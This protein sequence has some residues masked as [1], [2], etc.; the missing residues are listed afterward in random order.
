MCFS[1]QFGGG[2]AAF[3]L[4]FTA[5][6]CPAWA[7]A[8]HSNWQ[9]WLPTQNTKHIEHLASGY[10]QLQPLITLIMI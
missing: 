7:P 1:L 5:F 4:I 6:S 9:Q 3:A 10:L 2:G 8:L